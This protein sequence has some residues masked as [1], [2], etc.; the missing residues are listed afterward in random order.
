[1]ALPLNRAIPYLTQ[2][3][4]DSCISSCDFLDPLKKSQIIFSL[5]KYIFVAF[6]N[7]GLHNFR[8]VLLKGSVYLKSCWCIP[9]TYKDLIKVVKL[10]CM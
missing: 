2:S 5:R 10:Q 8:S 3:Q 4:P 1:M 9:E 7:Q 6:V